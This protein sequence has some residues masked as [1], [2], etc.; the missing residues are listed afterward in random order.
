ML[1]S[2]LKFLIFFPI[3]TLTYYLVPRRLRIFW[4]L[5]SSYYF[6]MSWN[7]KYAVLLA[8]CTVV[9]YL[10]ALAIGASDKVSVKD[11]GMRTISWTV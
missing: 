7:A 10:F 6:Y 11:R 3:V 9:S 8:I 1:F 4:L 2:S 5:I